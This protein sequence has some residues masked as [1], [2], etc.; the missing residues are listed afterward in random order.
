M[1]GIQATHD[2]T[3][4]IDMASR[5]L[6]PDEAEGITQHQIAIDMIAVVVHPANRVQDLALEQLRGI[7]TA[8]SRI[9]TRS[10]ETTGPLLS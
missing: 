7:Y 1:V 3:T 6:K 10:V 5:A 8:R 2:G 4:D 9:G